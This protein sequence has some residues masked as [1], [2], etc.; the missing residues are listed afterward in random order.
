MKRASIA[1]TATA[2]SFA[3]R[4]TCRGSDASPAITGRAISPGPPTTSSC[5]PST[6][7]EH[8]VDCVQCH[9]PI[10][11]SLE[12]NKLA[13][14]A[15]DCQSCHPNHHREQLEMLQG[16]GAKLL[17][18]QPN[19]MAVVRVECRTC[20]RLQEV[21]PAGAVIWRG[22]ADMC[23]MCHNAAT[24]KEF[25]AYHKKLRAS[26]PEIQAAVARL[27]AAMASA[28]LPEKRAGQLA[29]EL[30]GVQHDLDFLRAGNDVHN[31]H[32]AAKLNAALVD[33][34]SALCRE[35]KVAAPK[36]SLPPPPGKGK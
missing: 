27:R 15:A 1:P 32:Y 23:L 24:V 17:S 2:T 10:E 8:K 21:S 9:T 14:A 31:M 20:H 36:V 19:G 29:A 28:K 16:R 26:L 5:T 35:L 30:D 4:A 33:R 18:A 34:V 12:H 6:S 11:H 7:T 3:A 22:S 13:H 25:A